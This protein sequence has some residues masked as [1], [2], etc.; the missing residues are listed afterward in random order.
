MP[1]L[2]FDTVVGG[3]MRSVGGRERDGRRR[4]VLMMS[5]A[6]HFAM[7]IHQLAMWN[8]RP[9]FVAVFG[10]LLGGIVC[11]AA[12]G[13]ESRPSD[14]VTVFQCTFGEDWDVNFDR[15]PDRWVRKTGVEFP[16][17]VKIGI[18]DDSTAVGEKCLRLD[19]DG[20][21]AG[22]STPPI[23][24]MSRFSY[25]FEAQLKNEGL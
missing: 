24:V 21:A 10:V 8:P 14:A 12:P 15:W 5:C 11:V 4:S 18:E 22:V 25:I 3:R 9:F 16:H 20:A 13:S 1:I 17:Y 2:T 19:L 7:S 6:V 23:R